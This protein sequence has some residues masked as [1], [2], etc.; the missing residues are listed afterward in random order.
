MDDL[1]AAVVPVIEA[2]FGWAHTESFSIDPE[3]LESMIRG[4]DAMMY[5]EKKACGAGR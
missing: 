3:F 4:A 1:R 5:Q 2:N